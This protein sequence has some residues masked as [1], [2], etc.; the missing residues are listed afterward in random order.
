[1]LLASSGLMAL[2][3]LGHLKFKDS[4]LWLAILVSWC[5]VLPEYLLNV[6]A[7]R[8]GHRVFSGA[9]MATFNLCTG[10]ICVALMSAFYL[11]EPLMERQLVGFVLVTIGMFLVVDWSRDSSAE[12]DDS[13]DPLV[14]KGSAK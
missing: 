8:Y 4:P 7:I 11:Q 2:A 6:T 13:L 10:V 3:W 9:A 1:M 5:I 12:L 14:E